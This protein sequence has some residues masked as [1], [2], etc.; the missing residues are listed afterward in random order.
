[1]MTNEFAVFDGDSHVIEPPALWEKYSNRNTV[2]SASTRCGG[3]KGQLAR[4]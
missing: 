3:M 4:I 2:C 1:M